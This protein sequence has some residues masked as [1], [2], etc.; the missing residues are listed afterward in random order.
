MSEHLLVGPKGSPASAPQG[1]D[2]SE[3][4]CLGMVS[5]AEA[6]L[7]PLC[8]SGPSHTCTCPAVHS[9]TYESRPSLP[10]A[11]HTG[12]SSKPRIAEKERSCCRQLQEQTQQEHP[13]IWARMTRVFYSYR[14][15]SS[16]APRGWPFWQRG[17]E[18]GKPFGSKTGREGPHCP[19]LTGHLTPS[20][21]GEDEGTVALPSQLH[22]GSSTGC[23]NTVVPRLVVLNQPLPRSPREQHALPP[24][25]PPVTSSCVCISLHGKK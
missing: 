19:S 8:A 6:G 20:G 24:H 22:S 3:S 13:S 15:C 14:E 21:L 25:P 23:M 18:D 1:D 12:S 16:E 2:S 9:H 4:D 7:R 10:P 11:T 17:A 5:W